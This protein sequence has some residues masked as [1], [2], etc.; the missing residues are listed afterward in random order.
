MA[1]RH[2][3]GQR[4]LLLLQ[5][6]GQWLA[7]ETLAYAG[8]L[9]PAGILLPNMALICGMATAA[10]VGGMYTGV[11]TLSAAS[12]QAVAAASA[13]KEDASRQDDGPAAA[14]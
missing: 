1:V 9:G 12:A 10:K 8:N 2:S 6:T 5:G 14:K 4:D 3:W 13:Y 11:G 7:S